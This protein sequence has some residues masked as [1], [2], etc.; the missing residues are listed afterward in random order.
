MHPLWG[1]SHAPQAG[2]LSDLVAAVPSEDNPVAH[3]AFLLEQAAT[4]AVQT[5]VK[6]YGDVAVSVLNPQR[7][8]YQPAYGS[9]QTLQRMAQ[10]CLQHLQEQAQQRESKQQ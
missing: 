1:R 8:V 2:I 6:P 10:E 5:A 4:S 3:S 7:V 9:I